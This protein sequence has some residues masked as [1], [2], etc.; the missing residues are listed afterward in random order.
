MRQL[1]NSPYSSFLNRPQIKKCAIIIGVNKTGNLPVLSAAVTG[2]ED[3]KKWADSQA[4]V[5]C[6]ITDKNNPVTVRMIKDVIAD[7]I[8]EKIYEQMIVY[9]SG[10]GVLKSASDELWLLSEA[11]QDINEAVNVQPSKLLSRRCG[12]PHVVFISD[13]CRSL[14]NDP[15]ISEMFGSVIFPNL[16]PNNTNVNVD[17]LYATGPGNPAYEVTPDVAAQRYSGL[18]TKELLKGLNGEVPEILNN[19]NYGLNNNFSII[20]AY[21]LSQYL[22]SAVPMAA[23]KINITLSQKPDAEVTSRTPSYLSLFEQS[24]G[25]KYGSAVGEIIGD[26]MACESLEDSGSKEFGSWYPKNFKI[27]KKV[28]PKKE[29]PKTE[30][31]FGIDK[32]DKNQVKP[33]LDALNKAS[34]NIITGFT[35]V[36]IS[37]V[38]EGINV[39]VHIFSENNAI[40]IRINNDLIYNTFFLDLPDG[41]IVPLGILPGFIGTAVFD[42]GELL[43]VNYNPTNLSDNSIETSNDIEARRAMIATKSKDGTF[44]ISD[45]IEELIQSASYLRIYKNS[46][47]TLALYA[48]YAYSQTGRF[49]YVHSIYEHMQ[50]EPQPVLFDVA[51]LNELSSEKPDP[52]ILNNATPFCPMLNQG[53]SYMTI[54]P[55]RYHPFLLQLARYRIP[56]LWTTFTAEGANLIRNNIKKL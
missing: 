40:Q 26:I 45:N 22:S 21:E 53:W 20:L 8:N 14:P 32:Y 37:N 33:I 1:S 30:I 4:I 47:P 46:D 6:L 34:K 52:H 38:S 17:I 55:D 15:L 28:Q 42:N 12:I 25:N 9:Y 35:I 19:Y 31:K 7:F 5:N 39:G 16:T 48:A 50:R 56:G 18:Y 10:H 2:A 29:E 36:G 44:K 51:M 24:L 49:A 3:F 41:R 54:N 11:P 43:N 27:P 23:E 13:A